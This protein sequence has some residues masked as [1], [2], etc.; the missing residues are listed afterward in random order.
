MVVKENLASGAGT[1]RKAIVNDSRGQQW[2]VEC[3]AQ[4]DHNSLGRY[5]CLSKCSNFLF[6]VPSWPSFTLC[7][8]LGTGSQGTT[9]RV[10]DAKCPVIE[11]KNLCWT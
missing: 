2:Y 3:T 7:R 8:I 10:S 9:E 4:A 11:R 1:G 6:L 5:I